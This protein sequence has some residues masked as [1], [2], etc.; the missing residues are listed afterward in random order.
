MKKLAFA[1][2]TLVVLILSCKKDPVR[3]DDPNILDMTFKG[4]VVN[5]STQ[6]PIP[7]VP[8]H[9]IYGTKCCGSIRDVIGGDSTVTDNNGNY[10]LKVSYSKPS[11]AYRHFVHVPGYFD[12]FYYNPIA[13]K[14]HAE[15]M[16]I[17]HNETAVLPVDLADTIKIV[18][19]LVSTGKIEILPASTINLIF[20]YA[21]VPITDSVTVGRYYS[22]TEIDNFPLSFKPNKSV[23]H[24][25]EYLELGMLANKKIYLKTSIYEVITGTLRKTVLDSVTL[26]QGQVYDYNVHY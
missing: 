9:I 7:N 26:T 22:E 15:W 18:D 19:G 8:V 1:F 17:G 16:T 5:Q 24:I 23:N 2:L 6:A 12:K 14:R 4:K 21:I 13:W 20:P 3:V 10:T 11:E 25:Y